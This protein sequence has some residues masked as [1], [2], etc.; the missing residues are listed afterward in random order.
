MSITA[1]GYVLKVPPDR[2]TL[3]LHEAE[4]GGSFYRSTPYVAELVSNFE[5]SRRAPLV[6][7]ASFE[8]G[9]L[10]HIADGKKGV[11]AGTGLSR[12]NMQDFNAMRNPPACG[13][14]L[15]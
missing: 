4:N 12:L 14:S 15:P 3:L 2:R 7:F 10:T 5:H 1:A 13:L 8:D 11:S 6:V 9:K